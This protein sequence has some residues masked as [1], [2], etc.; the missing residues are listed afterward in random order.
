VAQHLFRLRVLF[1][2]LLDGAL[3][4]LCVLHIPSLRHRATTPFEAELVNGRLTVT[5]ILDRDKAGALLPG[6]CIEQWEGTPIE[7]P[8]D[9]E[10]IGDRETAGSVVSLR[11]EGSA[12]SH[13]VVVQL[14]PC[15]DLGYII[16]VFFV[17]FVACGLGGFVLIS[18]P[19]DRAAG[20]VHWSMVCM[21]VATM[22]AWGYVPAGSILPLVDRAVFF[23]AYMGVATEFFVLSTLFPVRLFG[24]GRTALVAV[25]VPAFIIVGVLEVTYFLAVLSNSLPMERVFERWYEVFQVFKLIA[26]A[27]A[28][29]NVVRAYRR[30]ETLE[31]RRRIEWV[32]WG[33]V[34]G[35]T[36]FLLLVTLPE[37]F[38]PASP[39]PEEATLPFLVIIPIAFV[40]SFIKYRV[41]EIEVVIKRTTIYAIAVGVLVVIY[42]LI[43]GTVSEAVGLYV[44]EV[45][46]AAA[47]LLALAFEPIRRAVQRQVDRRFFRVR[48]DF[49]AAGKAIL[50]EIER[51]GNE[52]QLGEVILRKLN[53][54][55]PVERM[56]LFLSR[57]GEGSSHAI[58]VSGMDPG[59]ENETMRTFASI[60]VEGG[61]PFA[62][63][64]V[65]EP[66][67]EIQTGGGEVLRTAGF[68]LAYPIAVDGTRQGGALIVGAKRS[69]T[70]FT[71]EDID[72]LHQVSAEAGLALGRFALQRRL[73]LEQ[74]ESRKYEELSRMKSDFISYV[75]HE[76]RTPLTSIKMF[77]ELLM[78]AQRPSRREVRNH[79]RIVAGE[80]DRLSRTVTSIL[81][82]VWID[83]GAKQYHLVPTD[84]VRVVKDAKKEMH[85]QLRQKRFRVAGNLPRRGCQIQA[86]AEGVR[87]AL[88]NLIGN[89]IKYSADRR[90]ITLRVFRRNGETCASVSDRG[91]GMAPEVV[92]SLFQRFYRDPA[93][94]ERVEGVGLG[95]SIVKHIMKAH[96][97]R[98]EVQSSPGKG[99][100]MTLV[101]PTGPEPQHKRAP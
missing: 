68:A 34:I 31:G 27:A 97:G 91:L 95:L 93:V 7:T 50:Q 26:I 74:A 20:A 45:G 73:L 59:A 100:T 70:R 10:F 15:Y 5:R 63:P 6:M 24:P 57:E 99:T 35:P 37:L 82:T 32:L 96:G 76:L 72:L 44:P 48:Y 28:I 62:L 79:I 86:D 84:L 29:L 18:R 47:V 21:G 39:V 19:E 56:G 41:L 87:H 98:V 2:L 88:T 13:T 78:M 53:L 94:R 67:V 54:L 58:A 85:Y 16:I 60:G 81:D 4:L 23:V 8:K 83:Q 90:E 43:V 71:S 61:P 66:G 12:A 77:T 69:G 11:V 80:T 25:Y 14:I 30:T 42:A 92:Q 49:R 46:A 22:L 36:P 40:I 65:I 3:L 1:P 9:L 51:S 38:I 17:G 55:L 75:S 52:K 64:E 89:A 101:F 33:L